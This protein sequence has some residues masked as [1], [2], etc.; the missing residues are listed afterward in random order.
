MWHWRKFLYAP[1]KRSAATTSTVKSNNVRQIGI[2][3][4]NTNKPTND[5][6][7]DEHNIKSAHKACIVKRD[8]NNYFV[9]HYG[10]PNS[11]NR[12]DLFSKYPT[13]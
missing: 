9:M 11:L 7:K 5:L 6:D 8:P 3:D 10:M 13:I 2:I 1:S 4:N 12:Q